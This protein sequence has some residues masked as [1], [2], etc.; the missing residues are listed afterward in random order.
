[1]IERGEDMARKKGKNRMIFAVFAALVIAFAVIVTYSTD[2][3][4]KVW[5][6]TF[7]FFGVSDSPKQSYDYAMSVHV[8][9][10]GKADAIYIHCEDKNILIDAGDVDP[11]NMVTEYLKK[12]NVEKLDLVIVSHPDRDHIG[13]M[14]DVIKH[15]PIDRFMMPE[16]PDE[17]LPTTKTY[18]TMLLRLKEKEMKIDKPVAGDSFMVGN[19][20]FDIF[21]PGKQ[22][23][24]MN[25]NSIVAKIQYG[26]DRFLFTGDAEKESEKDMI[27]SGYDLTADVLKIGHHG[28]ATST[29]QQFLDAV[30]PQIAVI[31]VGQDKNNLPK[32][33]TIDRLYENN[34]QVYRTDTDGI[35]IFSTNGDGITILKEKEKE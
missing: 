3:S 28:S 18:E 12:Q 25:N 22:Y 19:M 24:N 16:V 9:D 11:T 2:S 5:K 14:P 7:E 35:V 15:F 33:S 20:Q 13:G 10:V 31:S 30:R 8:L 29:T 17:I 21:A 27:K 32:S 6:E 34:I 23:K 4:F 26:E 1:M